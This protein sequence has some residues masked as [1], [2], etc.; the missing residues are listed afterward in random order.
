M[1]DACLRKV[2]ER[3]VNRWTMEK[4]LHNGCFSEI[5]VKLSC[6]INLRNPGIQLFLWLLVLS[7]KAGRYILTNISNIWVFF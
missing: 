3:T 2:K 4:G 6:L 1:T 7:E 5:F